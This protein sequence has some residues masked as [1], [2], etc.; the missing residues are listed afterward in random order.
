MSHNIEIPSSNK[1][2][3]H[4]TIDVMDY[5]FK[6][7]FIIERKQKSSTEKYASKLYVELDD[8]MK[9]L[10]DQSKFLSTLHDVIFT[11]NSWFVDTSIIN[12]KERRVQ[13]REEIADHDILY[14][15]KHYT[16]W[17]VILD[18]LKLHDIQWVNQTFNKMVKTKPKNNLH[19][20]WI[21]SI[22][23]IVPVTLIGI[24]IYYIY[25]PEMVPIW[26]KMLEMAIAGI[27]VL[28]NAG[29]TYAEKHAKSDGMFKK[30]L[31]WGGVI[32]ADIEELV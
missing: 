6:L 29:I 24:R 4:R 14:E 31:T 25:S 21:I 9:K 28:A 13:F 19:L 18:Q 2:L 3:I 8:A 23:L 15:D 22:L 11:Y 7:E 5:V 30:V 32:L 12:K 17:G 26:S 27:F 1:E 10:M 20:F 16:L